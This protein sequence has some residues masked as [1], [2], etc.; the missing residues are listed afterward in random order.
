MTTIDGAPLGEVSLTSGELVR[1]TSAL[2]FRP[3]L[4]DTT[5]PGTA[6]APARRRRRRR[7]RNFARLDMYTMVCIALGVHALA[8][9]ISFAAGERDD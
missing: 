6:R 5:K 2:L 3:T 1:V 9:C 4:R 8:S 7:R